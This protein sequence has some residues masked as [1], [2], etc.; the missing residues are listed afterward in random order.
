MEEQ[1]AKFLRQAHPQRGENPAASADLFKDGWLDS[2]L[3]LRLLNFLE[4]EFHVRIPAFQVSL[5]TFQNVH[6]ITALVTKL[7]KA[8]PLA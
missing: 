7:Q 2:L 1:I 6:T 3:Q 4:Q 5:R 8:G